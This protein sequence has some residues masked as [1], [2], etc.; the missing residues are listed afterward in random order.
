MFIFCHLKSAHQHI[1]FLSGVSSHLKSA[2]RLKL[3]VSHGTLGA[4]SMAS[5]IVKSH[6]VSLRVHVSGS[7]KVSLLGTAL[8]KSVFSLGYR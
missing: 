6:V 3:R 1:H 5:A 4:F 7:D 2:G 8:R